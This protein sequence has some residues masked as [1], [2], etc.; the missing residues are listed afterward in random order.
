MSTSPIALQPAGLTHYRQKAKKRE[1]H[2]SHCP[3]IRAGM[4]VLG[5]LM[6]EPTPSRNLLIVQTVPEQDPADWIAIKQIIER[7]APDIEVR[8]AINGLP[9]SATARWQIKRPSLVFSPVR[10]VN[11][12][13]R[14]GAVYCGQILGKDEQVRRLSSIGI[15]TPKTATLSSACA[16]DP[17]EWGEYVIVKPNNLN[18]GAGVKLVRTMDLPGRCQ[19]LTGFAED[20]LIVE[21][22]I[23][24]TEDGT[25]A[26]YRVLSL[27]GRALYCARNQWGNKRPPLSEIAADPLGI[28]ASNSAAM[29]GRK[30]SICNDPEIISLG[31][32][33]HRAFPECPT[34]G[35]DIIRESQS[36]RLYVL[37][38]NPHGA[39]WHLSST[40]AKK[41]DTGHVRDLYAQFNALDLAADVLI[42]KTRAE[43]C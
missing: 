12:A 16:F 35:V 34:I 23:D 14:G 32:H 31:Q 15:L 8:I 25:P 28:I 33:A 17:E 7:K 6:Q 21:P 13:P 39:V 29:G 19:E 4:T 9:N 3:A 10:L 5:K 24:H 11:F 1:E 18:S 38:V 36:G 26:E 40:L 2:F 27:F 42:Q 30:R 37:E 43:A 41:M 22:Y 20:Q